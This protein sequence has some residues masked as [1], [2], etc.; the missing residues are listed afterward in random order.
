M[1]QQA[2]KEGLRYVDFTDSMQDGTYLE[3]IERIRGTPESG[4]QYVGICLFGP[5][6]EISPLT[7]KFQLWR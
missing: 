2:I 7:K 5:I 6:G 4:L 3:Q 1:R